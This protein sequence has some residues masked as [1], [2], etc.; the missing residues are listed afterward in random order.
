MFFQSR[1]PERAFE[2]KNVELK[3][4]APASSYNQK[5]IDLCEAHY[6]RCGLYMEF[7]KGGCCK[8]SSMGNPVKNVSQAGGLVPQ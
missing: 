8:T 2:K 6:Q 1:T 3:K 4:D 7:L 5:I